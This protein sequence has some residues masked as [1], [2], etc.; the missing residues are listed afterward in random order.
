MKR[1]AFLSLLL[2]AAALSLPL[3]AA[4]K[5]GPKPKLAERPL[6]AK[7]APLNIAFISYA[8]PQQVARDSE[9]VTKY[10]QKYL[11][12][13]VKGFVT[14][15]YGSAIEAMR[16]EKADLAFVDPL[17]F[18][19]AHEQIGARPLLLEIYRSGKPS[20]HSCIWVRKD[21]GL[22]QLAD[23]RGKSIAFADQ[24]DMSGHLMP[25]DVFVRAGLLPARRIE[26]EFFKQIYFAG[27]DEQAMRAMFNG[28]TDAAGVSQYSLGL[29]RGEERD[30]VMALA[31]SI[32]SPAHL[33]MARPGLGEELTQRI[34]RVLVALD[35]TNSADKAILDKLYGVQGYVEAQLDDFAEIAKVA[36]AY[37]FVK[38]PEMF[39]VGKAKP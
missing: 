16:S 13:A 29:L 37:G 33:L 8:N 15:D 35:K 12:M 11:G 19:M 31:T 38:K 39:S 1:T 24:V 10:L 2:T 7:A 17:A 20:Y 9:G 23:L 34:K 21:R 30:Q 22:K 27:G 3:P 5:A 36:A 14:L 26:G 4:E 25:R 6:N 28:F 18:M 32:E